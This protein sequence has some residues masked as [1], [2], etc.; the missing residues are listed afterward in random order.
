MSEPLAPPPPSQQPAPKKKTSGCLKALLIVVG[1]VAICMII[2]GVIVYRAVTWLTQAP[3]PAP[4][5]YAPLQ[6]SDGEQE[7]IN[8]IISSI[9]QAKNK[10]GVVEETS[11]TPAVFNGVIEKI[12]EGERFKHPEKQD[13]PLALRGGFVN[14]QMHLKFTTQMTP[15]Q[16]KAQNL[17]SSTP[18]Y[19]N[20]EAV[21]NIEIVEG[22]IKQ[23]SVDRVV[24]GGKD[25]PFLWR[26]FTNHFIDVVRQENQKLKSSPDNPLAAIKLLKR[27][28]DRLHLVLDGK[29]MREQEARKNQTPAPVP[30]I[31]PEVEKKS[32]TTF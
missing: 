14:N 31:K 13:I 8:R 26:L 28:G 30:E 6:L 16:I 21:F 4:A 29:K 1:A 11:I 25:A 17:P 27:E 22:E 19:I 23:L 5:V 32:S 9:E 24:I 18:L 3:Q 10:N 7:D 12:L 20:A 2:T 15:E